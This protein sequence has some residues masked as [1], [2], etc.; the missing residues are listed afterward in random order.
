[1]CVH[2]DAVWIVLYNSVFKVLSFVWVCW[3]RGEVL[4]VSVHNAALAPLR[5]LPSCLR[6]LQAQKIIDHKAKKERRD[7]EKELEEKKRRV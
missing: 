3:V 2:V 6:A 4:V 7:R 1:M 5:W